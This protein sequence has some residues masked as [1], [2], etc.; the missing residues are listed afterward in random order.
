MNAADNA[1]QEHPGNA[2]VV[3]VALSPKQAAQGLLQTDDAVGLPRWSRRSLM[4]QM[5]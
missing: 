5:K 2:G 1:N 4:V 3:H